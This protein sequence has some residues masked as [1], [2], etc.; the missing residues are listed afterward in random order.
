MH[1]A[2]VVLFIVLLSPLA[3]EIKF[4]TRGESRRWEIDKKQMRRFT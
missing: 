3:F 4:D 1:N 2:F